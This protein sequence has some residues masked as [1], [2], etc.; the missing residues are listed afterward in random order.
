MVY[1]LY[2]DDAFTIQETLSRLKEGL[3]P[4]DLRDVNITVLD[5]AEVSFDR[6]A[7]TCDTVPFLADKRLVIVQGLLALFEP[8]PPSRRPRADR[9]EADQPGRPNLTADWK[10]LPEYLSRVPETTDLVF[11]DRRLRE[12]NRMLSAIRPHAKTRVFQLPKPGELREWI[13]R[14]AADKGI[15]IE[16]RA[17]HLLAETI[18]GDLAV[19][20][21]ELEKLSTY[22]RGVA[23]RPEDVEDLVSYTKEGNIFGAVDA[24]M[25]GRPEVAIQAVHQLLQSGRPAAY[26]LT[27]MAR[28]VRLLILAK[29]LRSERVPLA[30]QGKRL[31]L[32]GYPL[33]KTLEQER[34]FSA[35]RL[36]QIHRKLLDADVSIKTTGTEDELVLDVLIAEVAS[37]EA[38]G[39]RRRASA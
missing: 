21:T 10:G 23:V 36:V 24:V 30:E 26:V 14:R 39:H 18:G 32:T 12:I 6:L 19:M 15:D 4:A 34:T 27:M 29:E 7:A 11:V 20:D 3:G 25:E 13:R 5:G 2:G 33:R 9:A 8:N 38:R 22:R 31:G 17:I 28:Q 16:P 1:L 37:K 35:E